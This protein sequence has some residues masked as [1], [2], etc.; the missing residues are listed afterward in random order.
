MHGIYYNHFTMHLLR[1]PGIHSIFEKD[2]GCYT[3][4]ALFYQDILRHSR[5]DRSSFKVRELVNW[6]L[7]H[8]SELVDYYSKPPYNHTPQNARAENRTQI[9][10]DGIKD[11]VS[12][13]LMK[14]IGT[15]P[16]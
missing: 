3:K 7:K 10:K 16:A 2:N 4:L 15:T 14:A 1:P 5:M 8:N 9:V 6:L 12:L 11:L 13:G